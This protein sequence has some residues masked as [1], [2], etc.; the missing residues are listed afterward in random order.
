MSY[1]MYYG[2]PVSN[3]PLSETNA[4]YVDGATL[5][6]TVSTR[7]A[8]SAP[9]TR[10]TP[11]EFTRL[12]EERFGGA[13]PRRDL[14]RRAW[15]DIPQFAYRASHVEDALQSLTFQATP[16]ESDA[17]PDDRPRMDSNREKNVSIPDNEVD[18]LRGQI[19]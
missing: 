5:V 4:K 6:H 19:D 3:T 1:S 15:E 18:I 14:L 16:R 17:F 13:F 8:C 9:A 11:Q 12:A 10:P 2:P 7:P